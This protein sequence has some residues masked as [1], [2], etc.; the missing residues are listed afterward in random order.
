NGPI[1]INGI[2]EITGFG[3]AT[4]I[5]VEDVTDPAHPVVVAGFDPNNPVLTPNAT[6]STNGV[7]AF[8]IPF[9]PETHYTSNGPKT[10][11]IFATDNARSVG[12]VVTYS[13]N[14]NPATQL[15]FSPTAEPPATALAGQNFAAPP[16]FAPVVVDVD[17]ANGNIANQ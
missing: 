13:F 14:L 6:N 9:N 12:N 8:S 5:T 10:L 16:G 15:V 7:G 11:K 2:S 1:T 3:N 17:D 4:W